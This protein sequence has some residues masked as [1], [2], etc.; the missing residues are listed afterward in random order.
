[1]IVSAHR[2]TGF[3]FESNPEVPL[4]A[5][6]ASA[7]QFLDA[8]L[9]Q[10][11]QL[12]QGSGAIHTGFDP[13]RL[14]SIFPGH[15]WLNRS[16]QWMKSRF[17][18]RFDDK[19]ENLKDPEKRGNPFPAFWYAISGASLPSDGM[20]VL[21]GHD[22]AV[23]HE[24]SISSE[25]TTDPEGEYA[26][27]SAKWFTASSKPSA[28]LFTAAF[29]LIS[30]AALDDVKDNWSPG[31]FA[32]GRCP[33]VKPLLHCA[34]RA[35][36]RQYRGCALVDGVYD[37]HDGDPDSKFVH[38]VNASAYLRFFCT[39]L[40]ND[41]KIQFE[42]EIADRLL[43]TVTHNLDVRLRDLK[44]LD[45]S[46][47]FAKT[48]APSNSRIIPLFVEH[49][50]D[51]RI[52]DLF[53]QLVATCRL[54]AEQ[55]KQVS[56]RLLEW[57]NRWT[58]DRQNNLELANKNLQKEQQSVWNRFRDIQQVLERWEPSSTDKKRHSIRDQ[59]FISYSHQDKKYQQQLEKH[60]N[61]IIPNHVIWHDSKI[62]AGDIWMERLKVALS[63]AKVAILLVS[64]EFLNSQFIKEHEVL[65]LLSA[66]KSHGLNLF[67]IVV[68]PCNY[69]DSV[70]GCYQYANRLPKA[71]SELSVPKRARELEEICRKICAAIKPSAGQQ[72]IP[73]KTIEVDNG[74]CG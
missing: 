68:H 69:P 51:R 58:A 72:D 65:P 44:A 1:M 7:T 59:I 6:E 54:N 15:Q 10:L 52:L 38:H 50:N 25:Q 36:K 37:G 34:V 17:S 70:L 9:N 73:I 71:L 57:D 32:S 21:I 60:L 13:A 40:V 53:D 35:D 74:I 47:D 26:K 67:P 4:D 39:L 22:F 56:T 27:L 62:E 29:C 18:N 2:F 8:C 61:V 28:V 49:L 16:L 11:L 3:W 23:I 43:K 48:C 66:Q 63:Q 14:S 31:E 20:Q 19:A 42:L 46:Q 64:I 41:A 55:F 12:G 30:G 45:P 5:E 24:F 33:G